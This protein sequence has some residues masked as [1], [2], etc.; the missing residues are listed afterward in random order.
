MLSS[1]GRIF[2]R[3]REL[4]TLLG[5]SDQTDR[6]AYIEATKEFSQVN[7]LVAL[8]TEYKGLLNSIEENQQLLIESSQ[9]IEMKA[10]V[11]E[12]LEDQEALSQT[13]KQR[14]MQKLIPKDE[15]DGRP[16]IIEIRAGTGGEEASLFCGELFKAYQRY[17]ELHQLKIEILGSSSSSSGGLKEVVFSVK[18]AEAW[19]TFKY[20]SGTH[21]VQRVPV[22]ETSGRIHTSAITVA[23]LPEPEAVDIDIETKDLRIDT[24]RSSG[25]GGQSVN[26]MDSAIRITHLPSGLVVTCQDEKSQF[27]NK[28]KAMRILRARLLEQMQR[29]EVQK[30]SIDRKTQVGT[31]DRSEKIRTYNFPQNRF[32]D[33]R[34]NLTLYNLHEIM[35]GKFESIRLAFA[36]NEYKNIFNNE[37]N[38]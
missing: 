3:Q 38:K 33:H 16:I 29:E 2:D 34:I 10:L 24:Y 32:T 14:L 21:R 18:G 35:E 22:T 15:N 17:M 27:K 37:A 6:K 28:A 1:F 19:T 4:E 7:E 26:T 8:I 25:P 11:Q 9:D 36:E 23:V 30:R 20:D 13:L 31:G 12:E 5:Q